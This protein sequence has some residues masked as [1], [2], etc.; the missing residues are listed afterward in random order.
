MT[1]QIGNGLAEIIQL[2]I[3][4]LI[5]GAFVYIRNSV[6]KKESVKIQLD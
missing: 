2:V 6:T 3:F 5:T 4:L 1:A